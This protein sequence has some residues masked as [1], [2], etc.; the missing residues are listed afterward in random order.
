MRWAW[1]WESRGYLVLDGVRMVSAR[2]ENNI[3]L[4]KRE[5]PYYHHHIPKEGHVMNRR[6]Y[7]QN[8]GRNSPEPHHQSP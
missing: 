7:L 6:G 2:A 4:R 8:M 5:N 3:P 1:R